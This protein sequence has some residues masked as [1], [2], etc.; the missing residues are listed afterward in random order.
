MQETR[1]IGFLG[2]RENCII[3]EI[4]DNLRV[5]VSTVT[6][7]VDKLE[8]KGLVSRVRSDKDRRII[9]IALTPRGEEIHK[10]LIAEF[11]KL[12]RSMLVGMTPAEQDTYIELSA[13]I[14]LNASAN[15]KEGG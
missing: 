15:L 14:A 11:E 12:C 8:A 3:R 7:L 2:S 10:F 5:A 9:N 6:G 13:K 4:A 1:A